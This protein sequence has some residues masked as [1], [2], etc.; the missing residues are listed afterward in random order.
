MIVILVVTAV[1]RLYYVRE[2]AAQYSAFNC[3]KIPTTTFLACTPDEP[4]PQP[5]HFNRRPK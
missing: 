4:R 2:T 3:S 5:L 1:L